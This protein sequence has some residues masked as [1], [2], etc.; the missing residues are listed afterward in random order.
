MTWGNLT[1]MPVSYAWI[2]V[3]LT[4]LAGVYTIYR[5]W[6]RPLR[7]RG[8]RLAAAA[9]CVA[10]VLL[11]ILRPAVLVKVDTGFVILLTRG[12][13]KNQVDSL[14]K[15]YRHAVIKQSPD[16]ARYPG[17]DTMRS[18]NELEKFGDA[19]RIIVG[20][21]IP[22]YAL[23]YV[24]EAT[25]LQGQQEQGV[26]GLDIP[27]H[28]TINQPVT[29][30]LSARLQTPGKLKLLWA[31]Q[32]LD[33][34]TLENTDS[35]F[36]FTF[37]PQQSGELLYHVEA[38]DSLDR[39]ISYELPLVIERES[40]LNI[41]VLQ[42]Y[43]TFDVSYL[44]NF[45]AARGHAITLRYQLSKTNYR[46]EYLNTPQQ[47][48]RNLSKERLDNVD[49]VMID[50]ESLVGLSGNERRDL[51]DAV[52]AGLGMVVLH[53]DIPS[54]VTPLFPFTLS[55]SA[56][57]TIQLQVPGVGTLSE[58][59]CDGEVTRAPGLVPVLQ[60]KDG[61]VAAAYVYHGLGHI[62]IQRLE[63][64]Y[65][66]LLENNADAYNYYWNKFLQTVARTAGQPFEIRVL[67]KT[68]YPEQP[69]S[70]EVISSGEVPALSLDGI[71]LPLV[72]KS[73]LEDVYQTTAWISEPGWHKLQVDNN[74]TQLPVYVHPAGAWSSLRDAEL[75][76]INKLAWSNN[77]V[78][79]DDDATKTESQPVSLLWFF[80]LLLGSLG[81]LW[82]VP[83]L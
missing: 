19:V 21:G 22:E 25:Y 73:T 13:E 71:P 51:E 69:V 80:L 59:L 82:L 7:F 45:L 44:K 54:K 14:R 41:V 17:G 18:F 39:S 46:F 12:Y 2:L 48:W 6:I 29:I 23:Q 52:K 36:S 42:R 47:P 3:S 16:A 65:R 31:G 37:L 66:H 68:I 77:V 55:K 63:G 40:L 5:E 11:L 24:H 10:A 56:S 67:N 38:T 15:I 8:A 32:A 43:P 35:T 64:V 81:F 74:S 26:T 34:T 53:S 58:S 1:F 83:R 75:T 62:G 72:E 27:S 33:S 50:T 28:I 76:R 9:L 49:L 57:D 78:P 30:L 70:I 61:R 20:Q 4:M 79:Q 60:N